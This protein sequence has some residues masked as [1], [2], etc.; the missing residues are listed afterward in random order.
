MLW[1]IFWMLPLQRWCTVLGIGVI[2]GAGSVLLGGSWSGWD[3]IA[4]GGLIGFLL[5]ALLGGASWRALSASRQVSMAPRGRVQLLFAAMGVAIAIAL[6][7]LLYYYL[8]YAGTA[9][10]YRPFANRHLFVAVF[11]AATWWGIASFIASRSPLAML[12]VLVFSISSFFVMDRLDPGAPAS[13]L[14]QRWGIA[15]PL[16][17]WAAFGTWYLRARRIAP[18]GWLLP[19]GQSV[20]AAVSSAEARVGG[21]SQRAALERLLLGGTS[22]PRL[23]VQWL[24]VGGLLL[25]L[26]MVIARQGMG[27]ALIVAHMAFGGLILGPAI[28]A[29]QSAAIARRARVLWLPSGYSRDQLFTFTGRTLLKYALGMALLFAAFLLMLWFTQPWRP[30]L[31]LVDALFVVLLPPLLLVTHSLAG[32]RE[33]DSWWRWPVVVLLCLYFVYQPLTS[34]APASAMEPWGWLWFVLA[35]V[36]TISFHVM[37]RH[38]WL[39]G[40]L[41]RVPTLR[42]AASGT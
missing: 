12:L 38:R 16:A 34:T 23:L 20:L 18:P 5:P 19:G 8:Y 13:Q 9:P 25:S 29:V 6:L 22:V 2:A 14:N 27:E 11:A 7:W 10:R 21:L 26:L 3:V 31:T 4:W 37:A 30:G 42:S 24:L 35:G 28:V 36:A 32:W 39:T 15:Y 17:L 41:P 1:A 40:D 33:R